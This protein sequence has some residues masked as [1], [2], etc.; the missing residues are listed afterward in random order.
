MLYLIRRAVWA[1]CSQALVFIGAVIGAGFASGREVYTFFTQYGR[2]SWLFILLSSAIMAMLCFLCLRKAKDCHAGHWCSLYGEKQPAGQ[3]AKIS[4]L[5]LDAVMGGAMIS[6]AGHITALV[7]PLNGAYLLGASGTIALAFFLGSI[8]TGPMTFLSGMLAAVHVFAAFAVLVFDRGELP[9]IQ[10]VHPGFD[11]LLMGALASVAYASLNLALAIGIICRCSGNSC[12]MSCRS[13]VLFG[14][15]M[16]GL[17]FISNYLFLQH[18][19]LNG[20]TFP[21]V[22]LLSRFGAA[23]HVLSI[24]VMYLAILTTLSAVLYA[25]RSGL[26]QYMP[27]KAAAAAAVAVPALLA[28]AGFEGIVGRWYT[29][30]GLLCLGLVFLPMAKACRKIS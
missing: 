30:A 18:P 7:V 4:L 9:A 1:M 20:A 29:P 19:E 28:S 12:R 17:L 8:N 21:M 22:S 15:W 2:W 27:R 14:L 13:A 5:F 25:L 10:P 26:E 16:T 24:A 6:A 23:G 3:W 11:G